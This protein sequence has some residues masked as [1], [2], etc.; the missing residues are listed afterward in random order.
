MNEKE[1]CV[2]KHNTEKGIYL[3]RKRNCCGGSTAE[4]FFGLTD[5]FMEAVRNFIQCDD[6]EFERYLKIPYSWG[7]KVDDTVP[8][9][10]KLNAEIDGYKG[11]LKK[12]VRYPL[13]DFE[14]VVLW[15][16]EMGKE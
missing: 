1:L 11:T 12:E 3:V 8:F 13:K 2:W 7:H 6:M 9:V 16:P 14:K 15:K 4:H 5:D 10:K